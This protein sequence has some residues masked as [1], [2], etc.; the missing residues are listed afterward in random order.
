[1][2]KDSKTG[3]VFPQT[4]ALENKTVEKSYPESP[5]NRSASQEISRHC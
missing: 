2:T 5:N 3:D 1:V 4:L